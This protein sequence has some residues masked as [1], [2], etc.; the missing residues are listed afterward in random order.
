M[1]KWIPQIKQNREV[2]CMEYTKDIRIVK[3]L[4]NIITQRPHTAIKSS[5]EEKVMLALK[6]QGLET[7]EKIKVISS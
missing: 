2:E 5:L 3:S 6:K 1:N 4:N 7:E